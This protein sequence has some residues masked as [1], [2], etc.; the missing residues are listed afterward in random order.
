MA[1][2][3]LRRLGGVPPEEL[4]PDSYLTDGERLLRVI[5]HFRADAD[6]A[7]TSLEDCLTLEVRPYTLRELSAMELRA[8]HTRAPR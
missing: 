8:V 6:G 5:S 7:S 3:Q 4:A 2:S 1:L